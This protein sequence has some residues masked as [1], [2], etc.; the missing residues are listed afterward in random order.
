[1][2][3]CR[4]FLSLLNIVKQKDRPATKRPIILAGSELRKLGY[5]GAVKQ[6][7]FINIGICC[8]FHHSWVT[9]HLRQVVYEAMDYNASFKQINLILRYM[10]DVS[11]DGIGEFGW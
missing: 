3:T 5:S 6:H 10:A 8:R 4:I 11:K 7:E 2:P 1:M 9:D